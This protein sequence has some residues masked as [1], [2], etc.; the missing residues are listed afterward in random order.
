MISGVFVAPVQSIER[1]Y[2]VA[3][4]V[5]TCDAA[6][7]ELALKMVLSAEVGTLAP[8]TPPVAAL[9]VLTV[10][11]LAAVPSVKARVQ[12]PAPLEVRTFAPAD[13]VTTLPVIVAVPEVTVPDA[14]LA[15]VMVNVPAPPV[16]DRFKVVL[17]AVAIL[18]A[19]ATVITAPLVINA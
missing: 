12:V 8:D 18:P 15:N 3:F 11:Q 19:S 16:V 14:P 13:K 1:Q 5:K 17:P 10:F 9:H 2:A 7:K 4:I 6:V